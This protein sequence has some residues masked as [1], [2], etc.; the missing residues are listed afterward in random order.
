MLRRSVVAAKKE[1]VLG[2]RCDPRRQTEE[3]FE[4]LELVLL[5][6]LA[7]RCRVLNL[8]YDWLWMPSSSFC[9]SCPKTCRE[10]I[11]ASRVIDLPSELVEATISHLISRFLLSEMGCYS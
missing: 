8:A 6:R 1:A 4:V 2:S 11:D 7:K 5:S 3:Q 9:L 10:I